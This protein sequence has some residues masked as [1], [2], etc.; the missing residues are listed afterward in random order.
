MIFYY[1]IFSLIS[2][3]ALCDE[4]CERPALLLDYEE[5]CKTD[6][7]VTGNTGSFLEQLQENIAAAVEQGKRLINI[8]KKKLGITYDEQPTEEKIKKCE[9]YQCIF[10][11]MNT[12]GANQYP[13][14]TLMESWVNEKVDDG[15]K[16]STLIQVNS[17][18]NAVAINIA[19]D[20]ISS[21]MFDDDGATIIG[22][23]RTDMTQ[24][25]YAS[26]DN[27]EVD[28]T[29][30]QT[31]CDVSAKLMMCLNVDKMCSVFKYP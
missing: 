13:N 30:I 31:A 28:L 19:N 22:A 24:T 9:Y 15:K 21:S 16:E 27:M 10:R 26:A 11:K 18:F 12:L 8:A 14:M 29:D 3:I 23:S 20:Q 1:M 17:C 6:P 5:S 25:D 4:S 7:E 2:F